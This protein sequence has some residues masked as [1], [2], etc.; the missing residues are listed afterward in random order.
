MFQNADDNDYDAS[1]VPWLHFYYNSGSLRVDCNE[2]GFNANN[3]EAIC[4]IRSSTKSGKDGAG[5][6]G[7]KG[8]G[9]KSMFKVAD[10]VWI[11]SREFAFKFDKTRHFGI[12]API[13]AAFPQ[14]ILEDHTSYLLQLADN[15]DEAELVDGLLNFDHTCLVFSRRL[16]RITLNVTM[17][18]QIRTIEMRRRDE[19]GANGSI[20][21]IEYGDQAFTYITTKIQVG[22]LPREL[23]RSGMRSSELVLAFPVMKGTEDTA[24][25]I[26]NAHAVLP[27]GQYGLKVLLL[28]PTCSQ[29]SVF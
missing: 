16:R 28:K 9:F 26:Q 14:P 4:S 17:D 15:C 11:C 22:N 10:V 3:V 1:V 8:I 2:I 18:N 20:T 25:K 6:T 29:A 12:I 27:I 19:T 23:K 7:E 24:W 5:R 13:W 21:V